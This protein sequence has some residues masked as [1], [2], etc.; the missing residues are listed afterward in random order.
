QDVTIPV[1]TEL[2]ISNNQYLVQQTTTVIA[3]TLGQISIQSSIT[4]TGQQ[5]ANGTEL[6]L[7]EPIGSID[8]LVV[9]SMNDGAGS[10]SDPNVRYRILQAIQNPKL[11]GTKQDYITWATS[12]PNI[13]SAYVAANIL[14]T[15]ILSI[16][17]LSGTNDPD[18]ILANTAMVYNRTST[19]PDIQSAQNYI[20]T[21]RPIN[22]N[23][24]VSTT[25]TEIYS[26][27]NTINVG[28]ILIQNLT[29]TTILPNFNN[30]TVADLIRREVRRAFISSP[31]YGTLIGNNRYVLLSDVVQAID[32]GLSVTG[33]VY[34]QILIDRKVDYKGTQDNIPINT[35]IQQDN[36]LFLVYDIEYTAINVY[37]M[38]NS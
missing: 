5:L 31:L 21:Q 18:V 27:A 4:G 17:V 8:K 10:E 36:N 7:T 14:Q 25:D 23:A 2:S 6:T 29:L 24:L 28:V 9:L 16:F 38:G 15:G 13:T 33:G 35:Q 19:K 26:E 30:M 12:Q 3:G 32:S 20:E 1:N 34:A 37:V 22:D 11:G